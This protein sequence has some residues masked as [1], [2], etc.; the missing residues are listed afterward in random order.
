ME[1][2]STSSQYT[3]MNQDNHGRSAQDRSVMMD[4]VD[5]FVKDTRC[6][7]AKPQFL[8]ALSAAAGEI[9]KEDR[10]PMQ[11]ENSADWSYQTRDGYSIKGSFNAPGGKTYLCCQKNDLL[12]EKSADISVAIDGSGKVMWEY[13]V[14]RDCSIKDQVFLAN[15]SSYILADG[16]SRVMPA[17]F[18]DKPARAYVVALNPDGREKW[19]FC[20]E[21]DEECTSIRIGTDGTLYAK[22]KGTPVKIG[23]DATFHPEGRD[24]LY[25]VNKD[26]A[27]VWKHELEMKSDDLFHE[28]APDGTNIFASGFIISNNGCDTHYAVDPKGKARKLALPNTC[29]DAINDGK[30]HIFY[31]GKKGEFHGVDTV[32][33]TS[34]KVQLDPEGGLQT[35]QWGKD[36]NIY[37]KGRGE[38]FDTLSAIDPKGALLWSQNISDVQLRGLGREAYYRVSKDGSVFYASQDGKTIQHID[39]HGNKVKEIAV[40]SFDDFCLSDNTTLYIMSQEQKKLIICDPR[41]DD[42]TYIPLETKKEIRMEEVLEDGTIV[43]QSLTETY[44]VNPDT[45]IRDVKKRAAEALKE[46]SGE[47][48][49]SAETIT[50][51]DNFVVIGNLR[52]E[53]KE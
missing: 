33:G 36:G 49:G 18:N 32:K 11:I 17:G 35:P 22:Y 21:N 2:R 53:R 9:L 20:P 19:R 41:T 4:P 1:I 15:G 44:R 48:K 26:G 6:L 16:N 5:T 39:C 47:K 7:R 25:A 24:I 12:D 28:V 13:A 38:S 8:N 23:A 29:T 34:W 51:E 40:G 43:F 46:D 10:T 3:L 14:D 52:I 50:I 30:G 31:S 45:L 27:P 42:R 37:I